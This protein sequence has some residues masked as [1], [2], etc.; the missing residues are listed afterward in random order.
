MR[1]SKLVFVA[2]FCFA[3]T[4]AKA[5][6]LQLIEV[7]ADAAGPALKG[8]VWSPCAAPSGEVRLSAT[9]VV[10][11]AKDCPVEGTALPLV[12][13]SHGRRGSLGGH[14]DT[15]ETLADAGF[16]VVALN[17]P[18]DTSGDFTRTDD[19]SVL[20]ERPADIRRLIDF[21]LGAW[22]DA[23]R[24]DSQRIGLFG[25]SRGGY[26]GLVAIGGNPDFRKGLAFCPA[27]RSIPMCEQVRNNEIPAEPL[28]HDPRIKAAVLAD[29]GF[30]L[31]FAADDLKDVKVPIR[32]WGSALGGDGVV[33]EGVAAITQMLPTK[34]DYQVANA[35]HFAFL[36][37]CPPEMAKAVPLL[38]T[39]PPGFDRIAFHKTFNADT[40]AFFQRTLG[41]AGRP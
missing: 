33:P 6:G 2:A 39:D 26:T 18:G 7:P 25:F 24:I 17:H 19:L 16:V 12:V 27:E 11:A 37:P 38:C 23:A 5:A 21:M 10:P 28:T 3:A 35:G 41:V 1:P 40:L 13:I 8:A 31:L 29:P 15:A 14:H 9:L 30:A 22:P 4:C 36:T 20:I 32:L 34:P